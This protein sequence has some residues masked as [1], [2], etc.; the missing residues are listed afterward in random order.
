MLKKILFIII[1]ASS[2][3]FAQNEI[4]VFIIDSYVTPKPPHKIIISFFTNEMVKS[5]IKFDG[6]NFITVSNNYLE[7][8]KFELELSK[9]NYNSASTTFIIETEDTNGIK[10][11]SEQYDLYLNEDYNIPIKD[12]SY[13]NQMCLGA[14]TYLIPSVAVVVNGNKLNYSL[15]KEFPIISFYNA[16]YNYPSSYVGVEYSYVFD[17]PNRNYLR[18]GYKYIFQTEYIKYISPGLNITTN[19][20]GFNGISPEITFGLLKFYETFTFYGRFRYNLKP[21]NFN[22]NFS[23]ISIGLFTSAI[24]FNF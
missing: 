15:T 5:K 7:D 14:V 24:S 10:G 8:H 19:F 4:E 9:L 3:S 12:K 11:T 1:I 23:E 20:N 21:S 13:L 2:V 22:E 16:G 17:I 6:N 18:V